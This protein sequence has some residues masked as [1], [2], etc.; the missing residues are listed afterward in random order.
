[1]SLWKIW[2][3]VWDKMIVEE[4]LTRIW[5]RWTVHQR[6]ASESL[7]VEVPY[8]IENGKWIFNLRNQ[9][10]HEELHITKCQSLPNQ[11]MKWHRD[12]NY[13]LIIWYEVLHI[14]TSKESMPKQ[15]QIWRPSWSQ[16]EMKWQDSILWKLKLIK[17]ILYLILSIVIPLY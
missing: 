7:G 12:E 16:K 1:M 3:V 14:T 10:S 15:D 13:K 9:A 2:S 4:G 8:V 5:S 17:S 11:D 6:R